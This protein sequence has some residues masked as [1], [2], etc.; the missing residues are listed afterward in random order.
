MQVV[1]ILYV[2]CFLGMYTL[3]YVHIMTVHNTNTLSKSKGSILNFL[4]HNCTKISETG[5]DKRISF[6]LLEKK[7][8]VQLNVIIIYNL[9]NSSDFMESSAGSQW[10]FWYVGIYSNNLLKD[11]K[12]G[13]YRIIWCSLHAFFTLIQ[14][15]PLIFILF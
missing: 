6:S 8:E 12:I 7:R 15:G 14:K 4:L 13:I 2:H 3:I 5:T 1:R 10:C 9:C 11:C